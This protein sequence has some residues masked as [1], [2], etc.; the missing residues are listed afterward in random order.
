VSRGDVG[1]GLQDRRGREKVVGR[2]L[3]QV[4]ALDQGSPHDGDRGHTRRVA[5]DD[6]NQTWREGTDPVHAPAG[7]AGDLPPSVQH[8]RTTELRP[9]LELHG[10]AG[11]QLRQVFVGAIDNFGGQRTGTSRRNQ[12]LFDQALR[13]LGKPV[14]HLDQYIDDLGD[15]KVERWT[16]DAPGP[17]QGIQVEF[18]SDKALAR[19]AV[20]TVRTGDTL[21]FDHVWHPDTAVARRRHAATTPLM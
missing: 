15:R 6:V 16:G 10:F 2:Q 8:V 18:W 20:H 11:E 9:D 4:E 21:A 12:R 17:D 3:D 19:A 7:R 14:S 13:I 1:H 5:G